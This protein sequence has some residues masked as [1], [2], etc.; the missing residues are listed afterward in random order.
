MTAGGAHR[1]DNGLLLR[2]DVHRLFDHGYLT[3]APDHRIRVSRRLRDDFH[4]GEYYSRFDGG[5][6]WV[7]PNPEDRPDSR[8]LEWHAEYVFRG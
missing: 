6:I 5:E 1:I 4:D 2:S 7:P 3:V 8:F